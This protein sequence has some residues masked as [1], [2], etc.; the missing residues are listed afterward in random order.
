MTE[1]QI[2]DAIVAAEGGWQADPAD[3]G[4]YWRTR[5]VGTN[6]GVTPAALVASRSNLADVSADRLR[7]ILKD[8]TP[9]EAREI[10]RERYIW[11]PKIN[12]LPASIRPVMADMSVNHGPKNAI[13]MLQTVLDEVDDEGVSIDGVIG[14][15]TIQTAEEA[16][17]RMGSF[18]LGALI[19]ERRAFY[20]RLI[21]R[22]PS[23][24]R[25]KNGWLRRAD[26]FL[27]QMDPADHAALL[28]ERERK[29]AA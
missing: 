12:K 28:I 5:L 25:F 16:E 3:R 15:I 21:A 4:N 23:Q 7:E 27:D 10:F 6:H 14:P 1:D 19:E 13:K 8:L 26:S 2:L 20:L 22:R 24:A 18:L 9:E 11:A 29:A 17:S